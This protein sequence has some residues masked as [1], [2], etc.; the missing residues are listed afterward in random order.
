MEAE[1]MEWYV[2]LPEHGKEA[3]KSVRG[4]CRMSGVA[5]TRK[6]RQL[7]ELPKCE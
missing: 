7:D 6:D 1:L 3:Y 5:S 4:D 2:K